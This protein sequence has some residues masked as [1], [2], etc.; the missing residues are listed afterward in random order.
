M[1]IRMARRG[2]CGGASKPARYI[3]RI[4]SSRSRSRACAISR[5]AVEVPLATYATLQTPRARD[6]GL[7]RR[8]L[9][10][11]SC[12]EYEAAAEAVPE[13]FGVAKSTV[14]RRVIAASA[15]SLQQLHDR[16][17]DDA[18]WLVLLLDG[19]TFASD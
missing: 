12:R 18:E 6:S 11:I 13:A 3:S 9:G 7:F 5:R 19:K 14:S 4:R 16:R 2:S 10:G 1:R 8:V 15:R 17:H